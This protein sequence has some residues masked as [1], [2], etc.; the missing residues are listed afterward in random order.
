M[1]RT[2]T[3][4]PM[5][6]A[7]ASRVGSSGFGIWPTPSLRPS[8]SFVVPST[9]CCSPSRSLVAP[10]RSRTAPEARAPAPSSSLPIASVSAGVEAASWAAPSETCLAPLASWR[11]CP[12]APWT[13]PL[14]SSTG[15]LAVVNAVSTFCTSSSAMPA[16]R[17]FVAMSPLTWS[18]P[19]TS[20]CA[21]A[22]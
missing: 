4:S 17:S 19:F 7:V 2:F 16:A 15:A 14:A 21:L 12:A 20:A 22:A 11:S 5:V 6:F 9:S 8:R 18:S 13:L 3:G 1:P 10:S